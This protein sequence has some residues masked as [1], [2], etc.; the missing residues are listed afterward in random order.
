MKQS[1]QRYTDF[2]S[3]PVTYQTEIFDLNDEYDP[4]SSSFIPKQDGV[5][6]ILASIVL[7]PSSGRVL[8]Q[9]TIEV[10][11][12]P[13]LIDNVT[14]ETF[15]I[16]PV[17]SVSGILRLNAGDVVTVRHLTNETGFILNEDTATHFEAS[18]FPSPL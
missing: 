2:N 7:F 4:I 8:S 13:A 14:I 18:R 9:L 12:N 5:Y 3:A 17:I 10:N 1:L 6:L 11:T 15:I 16:P